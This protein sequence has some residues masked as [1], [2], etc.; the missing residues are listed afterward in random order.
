MGART[1]GDDSP[2]PVAG[3][4]IADLFGKGRF[5]D[6]E[7]GLFLRH[8]GKDNS[9]FIERG[10]KSAGGVAVVIRGPDMRRSASDTLRRGRYRL[11][12]CRFAGR[13]LVVILRRSFG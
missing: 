2:F 5:P 3:R 8:R 12:S 10:Y 6:A 11:R 4:K 9:M 7:G 1:D 13:I